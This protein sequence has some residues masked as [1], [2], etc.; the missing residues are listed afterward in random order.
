[1][2]LVY[3]PR[4]VQNIL[5]WATNILDKILAEDVNKFLQKDLC[6]YEIV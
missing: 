2:Y 5:L 3:T 1:M 6:V 4:I